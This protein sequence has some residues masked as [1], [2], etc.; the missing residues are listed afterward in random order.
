MKVKLVKSTDLKRPTRQAFLYFQLYGTDFCTI[1]MPL[2]KAKELQKQIN[3]N[4]NE[5]GEKNI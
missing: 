2:D 3:R 5:A 1:W 4:V